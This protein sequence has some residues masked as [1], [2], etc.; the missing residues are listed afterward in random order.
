[1]ISR[2]SMSQRCMEVAQPANG[3][4]TPFAASDGEKAYVGDG[5]AMMSPGGACRGGKFR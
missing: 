4:V 2:A 3:L 5:Y 1:M